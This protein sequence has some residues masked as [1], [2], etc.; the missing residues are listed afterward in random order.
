MQF[1]CTNLDEV[2]VTSSKVVL[3]LC[4]LQYRYDTMYV[5]VLFEYYDADSYYNNFLFI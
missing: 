1:N 3:I 5:V 4:K 2:V